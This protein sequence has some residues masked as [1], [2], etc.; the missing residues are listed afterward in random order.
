MQEAVIRGVLRLLT[1][2][3]DFAASVSEDSLGSRMP[4]RSNE[5]GQ[6]LWCVIGGHESGVRALEH[7]EWKGFD[8]S[9]TE[10]KNKETLVKALV[11]SN[12][13]VRSALDD[14]EWTSFGER[15]AV[16]I[17]EH[18]AMHQGQL[19]RFAYAL[20]MPFPESWVKHWALTD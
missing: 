1:E 4:G 20:D 10:T 14:A 11:N 2:Y 12:Q 15:M 6:Q 5:V 9:L 13:L 19:I 7:G 3:E 8:C 16:F 18:D 17:L